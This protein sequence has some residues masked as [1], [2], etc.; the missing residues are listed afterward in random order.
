[1]K[2]TSEAIPVVVCRVL[3]VLLDGSEIVAAGFVT[4]PFGM[5]VLNDRSI[6]LALQPNQIELPQ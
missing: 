2:V 1:M 3:C 6:P 5:R 4:Q